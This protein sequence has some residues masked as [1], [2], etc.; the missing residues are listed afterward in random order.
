MDLKPLPIC[1][2]MPHVIGK[3]NLFI[4]FLRNMPV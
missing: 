4:V 1:E 2:L 3:I